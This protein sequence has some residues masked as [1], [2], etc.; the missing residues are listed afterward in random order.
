MGEIHPMDW[1]VPR[2]C[3]LLSILSLSTLI[4]SNCADY[5]QTNSTTKVKSN[6]PASWNAASKGQHAQI[7][8]SWLSEFSSP[9]MTSLVN[10]AVSNNPNLNAVAARLRVARLNTIGTTANRLPSLS[11]S[12]STSR[13]RNGNGSATR[14]INESFGLSLSAS[15]EPDIW[16][17]LK[18]LDDASV[19]NY[20]ASIADFRNARLSLAA[21]TASAYCNL[22]TAGQ[23]LE[24]A[25]Q[26]LGS[27][28]K[29]KDIIE[30]NYKAGVPGTRAIDVQ[31]SRTNVASAERDLENS[32]LQRDDAARALEVLLGRYP[33]SEIQTLRELP[34]LKK[35]I[36]VGLPS[37]LVSR[38]PDL[39]AA[40]LDVYSSAKQADA[41]QKNLLP[42]FNFSSS[43]STNDDT[44]RNIF[45]PS[46]IAAN[47]AASL[48]QTIYNGGALR[49]S[50][51]AALENNQATIYD[52]ST[53][54]INAFREVEDAIDRDA[55]LMEQESLLI[56]E[57]KQSTLA[58][59]SA[60]LDYSEGAENSG[61]IEILESQRRANDARATLINIR[62][63]RLQN[64]IDL[65]LALGGDYRTY[66]SK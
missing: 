56:I 14:S 17:Q 62:N 6:A 36:P 1:Q 28:R 40:Q 31:L 12:A 2:K 63:N 59:K 34:E 66:P 35:S 30:R 27:F 41:A 16:G 26:T 15:W 47:I 45:D 64:R 55:S 25:T 4:L 60:E 23:Q 51:K 11:G 43:A 52:L 54:A 42:S 49:A 13:S 58:E 10:E 46:F 29:N 37:E 33:S 53:T 50:A 18:D 65:H 3:T 7:S 48:T 61:I 9:A 24:L 5:V 21:N 20:Q 44:P 19:S 8:T 22:V 57:V 38:R 39:I 32:R